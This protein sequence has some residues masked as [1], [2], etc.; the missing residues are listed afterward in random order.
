MTKQQATVTIAFLVGYVGRGF[1]PD[2]DLCDYIDF[3]H[4]TKTFT[5][6]EVLKLQPLLD[7]AKTT[8]G[9]SVYDISMSIFDTYIPEGK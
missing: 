2:N 3:E 7:Q 4:G 6:Q 9:D 5:D 1:H 8:L